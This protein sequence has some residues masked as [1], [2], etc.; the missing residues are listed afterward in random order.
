[1]T[2]T[3]D[4]GSKISLTVIEMDL[5][6]RIEVKIEEKESRRYMKAVP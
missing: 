4:E 1:V 6:L 5:S 2:E 3:H